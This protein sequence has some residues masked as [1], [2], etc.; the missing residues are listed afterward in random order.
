MPIKIVDCFTFYN[1]LDLLLYRLNILYDVVDYFIIVEATHTFTGIEK[2]L[3]FKENKVK[4]F[5]M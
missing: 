5:T 1:E 4:L 2:N 3:F